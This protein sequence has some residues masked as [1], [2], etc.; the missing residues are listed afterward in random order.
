MPKTTE[1]TKKG[2]KML[3]S[4]QTPQLRNIKLF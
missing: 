3:I 2:G 4:Q 1:K